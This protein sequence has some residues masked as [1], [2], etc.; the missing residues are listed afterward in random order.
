MI[1]LSSF[2]A[3]ALLDAYLLRKKETSVSLDLGLTRSTVK[4]EKEDFTFP[5]GSKTTLKELR[6]IH[7]E[8]RVCYSMHEGKLTKVQFFSDVT[9]KFYKLLPSGDGTAPTLEISGIRMHVIVAMDPLKDTQEKIKNISPV[10]G[11]VLD[12]CTGLG[13]TAI[14]CARSGAEEVVTCE[15]DDG[16]LRIAEFNPWSEDLFKDNK[17]R[18]VSGDAFEKIKDMPDDCYDRIIHDPPSFSLAGLLYSQKFYDQLYR[19]L[20]ENGRLYHYTGSPGSKKRGVNLVANV[21]T[22]LKTAGFEDVRPAHYGV[23]AR[24]IP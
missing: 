22:R 15:I 12:T 6:A 8:T 9:N 19:V 2:Q 24:K 16:S 14:L 17:I 3:K 5:D 21:I 11:K 13:Y 7:D 18:L 23:S 20:K 1:T 4:I 10:V